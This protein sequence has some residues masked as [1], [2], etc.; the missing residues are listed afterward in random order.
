[1]PSELTYMFK[2]SQ[3]E[4]K[5][6]E[7]TSYEEE[8]LNGSK[9]V[10]VKMFKKEG[11]TLEKIKI[12]GKDDKY[13][14]VTIIDGD[15]KEVSMNKSEFVAEVKKNKKLKFATDFLKTQMGGVSRTKKNSSSKSNGSKPIKKMNILKRSSKKSSKKASKKGSTMKKSSK[16]ASKKRSMK[17][18]NSKK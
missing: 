12:T 3:S 15:K 8:V 9:G 18:S 13:V 16:K 14:M 17:K 6:G 2:N 11:S 1:M 4:M 5:N 7:M 10:T